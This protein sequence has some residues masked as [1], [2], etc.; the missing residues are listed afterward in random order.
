M[1]IVF[2]AQLVTIIL[3]LEHVLL[4]HNCPSGILCLPLLFA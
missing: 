3:F 2:I 1:L 4:P